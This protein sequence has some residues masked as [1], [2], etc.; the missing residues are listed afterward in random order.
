MEIKDS[1]FDQ[2]SLYEIL[3]ELIKSYFLR[4][5]YIYKIKTG[6]WIKVASRMSGETGLL[7]SLPSRQSEHNASAIFISDSETSMVNMMVRIL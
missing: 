5:V 3:K 2:T 1:V 4:V 6:L 7:A